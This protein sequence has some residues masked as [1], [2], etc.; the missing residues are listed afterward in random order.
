M[1]D[2]RTDFM[3]DAPLSARKKL[4]YTL[5]QINREIP[6]VGIIDEPTRC[7]RINKEWAR[8]VLGFTSLLIEP[9]LW[10][11]ADDE[12]YLPI[13]EIK[14]FLV[15]VECGT[16]ETMLLR[17]NPEND[18]QLQY[19]TDNGE[20]WV[21]AFDYSLCVPEFAET[22][23]NNTTEIINQNTSNNVNST[24]N[25]FTSTVWNNYVNNYINSITD[26]APEL[27]YGDDDDG[28][29]DAALCHALGE[30]VDSVCAAA[31]A[32]FDELDDTANDL[33]TTLALAAAIIGIVA[34]AATG[35]GAIAAGSLAASATALAAQAGF[36]GA[37]IAIGSALGGSLFDHF[38]ETNREP[39]EDEEAKQ[40]VVCCLLDNLKGS[41]LDRDDFIAA[42]NCTGLSTEAQ[43]VFDAANI[44]AQEE[45]TYAALVENLR[46]GY[47]SAKVGI[48]TTCD[49]PYPSMI[50]YDFA[51][52]NSGFTGNPAIYNASGWW[53]GVQQVVFPVNNT[54]VVASILKSLG[55]TA[56]VV[57]IGFK[58]TAQTNCGITSMGANVSVDGNNIGGF[59]SSPVAAGTEVY[60]TYGMSVLGTSFDGNGINVTISSRLCPPQATIARIF[61]VRVW[62]HPESPIKGV[63]VP[64]LPY[65][66]GANGT[67]DLAWW[68]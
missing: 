25:N 61:K 63:E 55:A 7:Y 12:M 45:A 17:Q 49:C 40:A 16:D 41:N 44:F 65:G 43:A 48:L 28:F 58:Y 11:D 56:K 37:G 6:S 57:G 50:E 2:N 36:W 42:F 67:S 14:T 3:S 20:T 59:G 9:E 32:F 21:L 31:L 8:F 1:K 10:Q 46:I 68:T 33:R 54:L 66:T 15:G 22:I 60:R 52:G 30:F 13:Q 34:L 47:N 26:I 19:S 4:I 23:I 35:V 5:S 62:L 39:Y 38:T 18:C 51:D 53:D 29:R 64:S 27:G 24:V